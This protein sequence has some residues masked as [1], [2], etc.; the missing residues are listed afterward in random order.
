MICWWVEVFPQF[1][2]LTRLMYTNNS[3]R[4][5]YSEQQNNAVAGKGQY[6][7]GNCFLRT[8]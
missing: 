1:N 4:K 5:N 7:E 8:S 3:I 6:F 2:W